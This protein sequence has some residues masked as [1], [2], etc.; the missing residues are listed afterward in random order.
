M[1]L[2]EAYDRMVERSGESSFIP[3]VTGISPEMRTIPLVKLS[4]DETYQRYL[5]RSV[6][7]KAHQF[8]NS[9]VRPLFVFERPNG[10]LPI[11]DGQH[12]A[13]MAFL[14]GVIK[15]MD[16][17]VF[18]HPKEKSLEE[19]RS[20]EAKFFEK[21]NTSRKNVSL[22]DRY[23]SGASW[24]DERAVKFV[25]SLKEL[26]VQIEGLGDD[27]GYEVKSWS[28]LEFSWK[29]YYMHNAKKAVEFLINLDKRKWGKGY[30]NGG[31]TLGV[32]M[33]FYLL[34]CLESGEKYKGLRYFMENH[35]EN[36]QPNK[37]LKGCN[38]S[39]QH[40]LLL[41]KIIKAYNDS[42]LVGNP[43]STIGPKTLEDCGLSYSQKQQ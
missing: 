33:V 7:D 25:N 38:G 40:F 27:Y 32:T 16:C 6:L 42:L 13:L 17:A 23:R 29:E 37:W 41:E 36:T 28:K 24:G 1:T 43:G 34:E 31:L 5:S 2:K 39:L 3:G 35:F 20:I 18:V 9:L 26:G 19:C 8:N 12:E 21:L 10:E 11:V 14:S 4:I 30:I 15:E 22:L